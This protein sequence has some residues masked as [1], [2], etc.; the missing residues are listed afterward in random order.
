[1]AGVVST[2]R[3]WIVFPAVTMLV[4]ALAI[5]LLPGGNGSGRESRGT[6]L[7]LYASSLTDGPIM[8]TWRV[9]SRLRGQLGAGSGEVEKPFHR[10]FPLVP[11]E[12]VDVRLQAGVKFL[13][14]VDVVIC[15]ATTDREVVAEDRHVKDLST[16]V[17][18]VACPGTVLGE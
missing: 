10:E 17:P 4:L 9:T 5:Q 14:P 16:P 2:A 12:L 6:R 15:S 8:V 18:D 1:M 3:S 7:E 11:G 13:G